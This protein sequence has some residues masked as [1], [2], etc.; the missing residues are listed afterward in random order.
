MELENHVFAMVLNYLSHMTELPR[1][2]VMCEGH[3]IT[4]WTNYS[5]MD[6]VKFVEDSLQKIIL[7]PFL[8]T[9]SHIMSYPKDGI[10]Y[11]GEYIVY[12]VNL[13]KN[14]YLFKKV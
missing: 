9:S 8:S 6:Q 3:F 14:M 4:Y 7:G 1:G 12:Y 10:P 11:Q 13:N 5:K 2:V